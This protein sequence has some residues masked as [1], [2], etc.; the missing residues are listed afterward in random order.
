MFYVMEKY[1]EQNKH[2][3]LLGD[4]VHFLND[5]G[6]LLFSF[7]FFSFQ[8]KLPDI[9]FFVFLNMLCIPGKQNSSYLFCKTNIIIL[10][11]F[12]KDLPFSVHLGIS[13]KKDGLRQKS[14][15]VFSIASIMHDQ[16]L[17]R[18]PSNMDGLNCKIMS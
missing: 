2:M 18:V 10:K 15:L 17:E 9:G 6:L 3:L 4:V 5:L 7:S 1:E 16:L 14:S 13:W 12:H 8:F 11:V